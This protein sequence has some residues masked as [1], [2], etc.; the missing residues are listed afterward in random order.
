MTTTKTKAS[1]DTI[2][3]IGELCTAVLFLEYAHEKD[4]PELTQCLE[5]DPEEHQIPGGI[6]GIFNTLGWAIS[7]TENNQ[8]VRDALPLFGWLMHS[9]SGDELMERGRIRHPELTEIV[10]LLREFCP[11]GRENN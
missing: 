3:R 11:E 7:G 4:M 6:K 9:E 5:C 2:E 10:V 8:M 1:D